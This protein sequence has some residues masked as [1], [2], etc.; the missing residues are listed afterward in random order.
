MRVK[1]RDGRGLFRFGARG[2][3]AEVSF[4][5]DLR[6]R[7]RDSARVAEFSECVNP[8]AAGT[9]E[10]EQ[11]GDF[12][13]GFAGSIVDGAADESVGPG[14]I[15]GAREKEVGVTAGDDEGEGLRVRWSGS[16]LCGLAF[17]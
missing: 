16:S 15:S 13:E 17:L 4:C 7:E 5:F 10:A 2:F 14:A 6:E 11:F 3:A 9:A 8:W 1:A 12:I